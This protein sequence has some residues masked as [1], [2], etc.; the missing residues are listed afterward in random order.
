MAMTHTSDSTDQTLSSSIENFLQ[1]M[2]TNGASQNTIRAYRADLRGLDNHLPRPVLLERGLLEPQT[3]NYLTENRPSWKPNTTNRKLACFRKFGRHLGWPDFLA[4]YRPPRAEKG[5]AHPLPEGVAG[6]LAMLEAA[7]KPE[8]TALVALCGL[9]GL[10][11]GEALKVRPSHFNH[12]R[13]ELTVYGKG[14]KQRVVP[15]HESVWQYLVPAM[16]KA[17][18]MNKRLIP[19][20]DRTA[21][22]AW[23]SMAQRAG[24]A[25]SA[26]HDGRM[27]VGTVAY[28]TSGGDIRAVQELLGHASSSTTE[29]YTRVDYDKMK[30]A[31]DFFGDSDE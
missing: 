3:A 4:E 7:R 16:I 22:R 21:R 15:V 19:L 14:D 9:L 30:R 23:T 10:R 24:L 27:T 28:H 20:H 31:V 17:Q 18:S 8:H 2:T 5:Y 1:S 6:I 12:V 29:T 25:H 26:T 13:N 11:V